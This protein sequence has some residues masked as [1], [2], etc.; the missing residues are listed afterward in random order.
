MTISTMAALRGLKGCPSA[1]SEP[2]RRHPGSRLPAG[3]ARGRGL[4]PRRRHRAESS[5]GIQFRASTVVY[6]AGEVLEAREREPGAGTRSPMVCTGLAALSNLV[7][8][9]K[10]F[11]NLD[12][13]VGEEVVGLREHGRHGSPGG[14]GGSPG[15]W[16]G[17]SGCRVL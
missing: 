8:R 15:S 7:R 10:Q 6:G 5:L 17:R 12:V 14:C 9:C 2:W 1:R 13:A 16:S 11:G 3:W 4:R